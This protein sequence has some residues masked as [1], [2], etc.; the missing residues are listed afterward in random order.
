MGSLFCG[1]WGLAALTIQDGRQ[2]GPSDADP[3]NVK[4]VFGKSGV[5]NFSVRATGPG[6]VVILFEISTLDLGREG[7]IR[8]GHDYLLTCL[9]S[10]GR[11]EAV[12]PTKQ[13]T[14][15]KISWRKN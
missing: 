9:L 7:H 3:L 6:A 8:F 4:G 2:I 12:V 13:S 1:A 15:P 11:I 5:S 10:V 14:T